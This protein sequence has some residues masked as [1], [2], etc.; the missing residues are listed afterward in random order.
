MIGMPMSD[1]FA[2]NYILWIDNN[3]EGWAPHACETLEECYRKAIEYSAYNFRIT[4]PPITVEF[5]EAQKHEIPDR[6]G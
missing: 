3:C 5:R 6:D 1:E 2:G 4:P